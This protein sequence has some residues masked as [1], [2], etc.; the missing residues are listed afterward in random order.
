MFRK[1][2]NLFGG[3][4]LLYVNSS[5]PSRIRDDLLPSCN[6]VECMILELIVNKEKIFLI[7]LY[8]PPRVND[9]ILVSTISNLLDKC[10]LESNCFYLVGD[11]NVNL[12][13]NSHSLSTVFESYNL[14]NIVTEPTCFK[15]T[16]NPSLLDP[17]VTNC[18]RR[19]SAHLN[20]CIGVSDFHNIVCAATKMKCPRFIPQL[21]KYRSYKNFNESKYVEDLSNAPF[22]VS[23]VFDDVDDTMWFQNRLLTD[24]VEMHAPSKQK[25]IKRKQVPYMNGKL[26][27]AINVKAMLRRK[28][29]K[30]KNQSYWDKYRKQRNYVTKLK[31][32]SM[33]IYFKER[34]TNTTN[35]KEFWNTISPFMTDKNCVSNNN[36]P[37]LENGEIVS[38]QERV[39]NIFN[40]YF[41]NIT[42][43]FSEPLD[44][45]YMHT[46]DL[47]Q[48]YSN[49]LSIS[50][51][52][53]HNKEFHTPFSFKA[54]TDK[55]VNDKLKGLKIKKAPG[56]DGIPAKLLK[57]G[58][59][60]LSPHLCYL[61]NASLQ[62]GKYP[63][64][65]KHAEVVP[66]FKKKDKLNKANFR[67]V[68]I[69]TSVSKIV[70]G[71]LCDQ[72][73]TF[74]ENILCKE[75]SAYRKKY[76]CGNV[77]LQCVEHWKLELDND[78]TVGC[79][80]MDLSK[81]FD[82]IPH[83][84]IIAKLA[85]YGLNFESCEYI[86]H[87]LQHRKQ[88]VK[89]GTSRSVWL[90][91]KRGVPQGSMTGPVLF[92]IF[93]NDFVLML[94]EKCYLYNYADDNSLAYTHK[95]PLIV[96]VNLE[97]ASH[98]ALQWFKSNF[99]EANPSK[100]QTMLL[101]RKKCDVQFE[102]DGN[103]IKPTNCVKLLGVCLD[104]QL[105]FNEHVKSITV[106]CARQ[107]SAMGRLSKK[108]DIPCK[109]K[110]LDAFILS[111]F[112]YCAYVYH[113]CGTGNSKKMEKLLERALRYVYLDFDC[114]YKS[115]LLKSGKSSLYVNRIKDI[116]ISV[117]KI[118]KDLMPPMDQGFFEI[119]PSVYSKR[120]IRL[121]HPHYN[122]ISYGR[123][124]L[125][126]QGA[127][128][129]NELCLT[130]EFNC[131]KDF[132][133]FVNNWKPKCSC[134]SCLLCLK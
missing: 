127:K 106:K 74:F 11:F 38:D 94:K 41:I 82:S 25:L 59:D 16:S 108:L 55:Q 133:V 47:V 13:E 104:D 67:P 5:L 73:M 42:A 53:H 121:K 33:L 63:D 88:R 46:A 56:Y 117:H 65:L 6:D 72:L 79:V 97:N 58:A 9:M 89:I 122:T 62:Q 129:F 93:L 103:V 77:L 110:I 111:N 17:I 60:Q 22:H 2:R 29:N 32:E 51:I 37:L 116:L 15:S 130:T 87:Y 76:G 70:E 48:H 24:V 84:L 4:I 105:T 81:A 23:T 26:R 91:M 120:Y 113:F 54:V 123:N 45:A 14:K 7:V 69:L 30:Y 61:M 19:L 50:C 102:I 115:L 131:L 27:K 10:I 31:R 118:M 18:P 78:N 28:F 96:K 126:Y 8:K 80:M 35:A 134:G 128:L 71:L 43:N 85:A 34:C 124:S 92:N 86:R 36:I 52:Q 125:R 83:G 44:M 95:D 49:H 119:S 109:R 132:K 39:T 64:M 101:S 3:G 68:S 99:M 40:D 20:S 100:F 90:D 114:S 1:D 75:L 12:M 112:N 57:V 66:L 107:I 98:L 21:I